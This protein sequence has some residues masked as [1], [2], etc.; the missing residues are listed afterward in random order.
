[1]KLPISSSCFLIEG[2]F[3][4]AENNFVFPN[5]IVLSGGSCG[6]NEESTVL[7]ARRG[8]C[9]LGGGRVA[10]GQAAGEGEPASFFLRCGDATGL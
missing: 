7:Y 6:P 3:P 4:Q 10:M 1:M 9:V 2:R 5:Q 8:V